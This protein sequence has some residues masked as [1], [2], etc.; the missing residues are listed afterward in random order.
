MVY[1]FEKFIS[2]DSAQIHTKFCISQ[3]CLLIFRLIPGE[4]RE[5]LCLALVRFCKIMCFAI[6]FIY[7][8]FNELNANK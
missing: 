8:K 1:K 4:G 5:I 7:L 3:S 6:Y 2:E